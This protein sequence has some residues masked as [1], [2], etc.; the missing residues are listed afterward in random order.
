MNADY[1][2][3]DLVVATYIAYKKVKMSKPYDA[4]TKSWIFDNSSNICEQLEL[5]VRNGVA[6]ALVLEYEALR[7]NLLGMVGRGC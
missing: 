4:K 7:R 5:D 3:K 1:A 2:V 6:S